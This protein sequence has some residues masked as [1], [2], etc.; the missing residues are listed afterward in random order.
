MANLNYK[1]DWKTF[2]KCKECWS[3][4]EVNLDNWYYHNEWFLWVL[5]RC[6]QCILK[7]RKT[8]HELNMAR[9]RDRDRYFNNKKRR[10]FV[11]NS[12]KNRIIRHMK[13]NKNWN[14][15]HEKAQRL[16]KKLWIRPTQCPICDY[17][18]RIVAH[19]LDINKW[20]EIVFCC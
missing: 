12:S 3:F 8:E 15:L 6:K 17:K 10:E 19:H 11:Y 5:W 9:K 7:W 13:E 18:W 20:N 2:L 14:A 4:K 16:I 1:K